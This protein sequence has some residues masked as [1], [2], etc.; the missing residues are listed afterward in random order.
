MAWFDSLLGSVGLVRKQYKLEEKPTKIAHGAS[1]SNAY[2][3]TPSYS[4]L[5]SLAVY[6]Q[7]PYV[8]A[9][10]SRITQDLAALPIKLIRGKSQNAVIVADHP[11]LDLIEQP[12]TD[13]DKFSFLEQMI[14]DL[15]SCG[16]CYTLL[17]GL[18]EQPESIVRLHPEQVEILT[19]NLGIKAYRYNAEGETV[20]YPPERV[21]HGKNAS[22]STGVQGLYGVGAIQPIAEEIMADLNI[23][24]L[25]SSSSAK[26]RPDVILS[27]ASDLDVWDKDMRKQILDSYTGLAESGGCLVTSGMLKV[28]FT[29][30]TPRDVEFQAAREY[31]KAAITSALGCPAS[32]LG[33]NSAN[34]A[35]ARQQAISY[36]ST[37]AKRGKRVAHLLSMIAKKWDSSLR[38]EFDYSGVEA[39][40]SMRTEQLQRIKMHI[41]N[42]MSPSDAYMYEGLEDA[43]IV[44]AA[45]REPVADDVGDEEDE[46]TR[47]LLDLL[48]DDTTEDF[49]PPVLKTKLETK[50][51]LAKYGSLAEAFAAL[52][53]NTQKAL[54]T[55]AKEHNEEVNNAKGKSTTKLKLGG[56][57]W[58]GIGAFGTNPESVRP[59]VSSRDQWAMGRVNSFLYALRN[60]R[61]R[62]GKHDQDLLPADHPMSNKKE[63]KGSVG[64][65]D[66]TN[67][68]TDKENKKVSLD[69]S[70]YRVFDVDYAENLK[71]NYPAIWGA[72]GNIEGNNQYRRL[73]PIAK[74]ENTEA[75]T[76]TEELAI[77]K[78]EAWIARHIEDGSQFA[79]PDLSPNVSNVG[80]IVAQIKWLAVGSIGQT[81]MKEVLEKLKTKLD[82][83][84]AQHRA[85]IWHMWVKSKQEPAERMI[86][87]ATKRYL[88]K[89]AKR[90]A[91]RVRNNV[92]TKSIID[93]GQLQAIVEEEKHIFNEIGG[94]WQKVWG[95]VGTAE[96]EN[97]YRLA[98]KTKPIDVQFSQRDIAIE[99]IDIMK[100][101]ISRTTAK[102]VAKN[103]EKGLIDGLSVAEIA[104]GIEAIAAFAPSR[105]KAIA[106]TESTKA[107]NRAAVAAYDEAQ[108][109]GLKVQKEWLSSAD[110]NV[111]PTHEDLDGTVIGVNEQFVTTNGDTALSPADFGEPSEDINCRCTLI[112]V[113]E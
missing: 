34:Y 96:L 112:P 61:F 39:L 83:S 13:E 50:D 23:N 57:Y 27:P 18:S 100:K 11:F 63:D 72:G 42:G 110:G 102:A 14:L 36:W 20:D 87:A 94:A 41:D 95:L 75:Q 62:S 99:Q 6:A 93:L 16:N 52:P 105:A 88:K 81:K 92:Q 78:R 82:K 47:S 45:Q 40:N 8:Y 3:N 43:P 31:A 51:P 30:L 89:A 35:T 9:A 59:S 54:T 32:V 76:R 104:R 29:Q 67:F 26:G 19:D 28:D 85:K 37:L 1:W 17:L 80:G 86:E 108:N 58:R 55:K 12:N 2:G 113:V 49:T 60:G 84:K 109:Q 97:V 101:E 44:N 10:L 68:P 53:D 22:W 21:V 98:R 25:V 46:S 24:R 71:K 69:N 70:Q 111:R 38:V 106:R 74:R 65:K 77:R 5:G 48:I 91:N 7:H 4:Q 79:D 66:P 103:V 107:A 33:E 90:Y 73:Y 56:V 64:D 15:V